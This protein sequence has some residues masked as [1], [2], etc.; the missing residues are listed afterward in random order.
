MKVRELIESLA[1]INPE[2][3]VCVG[4]DRMDGDFELY[5]KVI[6]SN[7]KYQGSYVGEDNDFK[8][9][10]LPEEAVEVHIGSIE[11]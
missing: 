8:S 5:G 9:I 4:S 6:F 10:G 1:G 11:Q 7:K 2:A 3:E